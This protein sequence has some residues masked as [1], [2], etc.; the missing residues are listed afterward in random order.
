MLIIGPVLEFSDFG[1]RISDLS[2][3]SMD[4]GFEFFVFG[5]RC[6]QVIS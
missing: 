3:P 6:S 1:I 2:F 5:L 4:F